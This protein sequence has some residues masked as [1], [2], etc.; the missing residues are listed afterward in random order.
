MAAKVFLTRTIPDGPLARLRDA[1]DL[2]LWPGD[3]PPPRADLL[4]R[5]ADCDGLL[6]LLTDKI[7]G[8]LLDAAPRLRVVSQMAVGYE[9][10][11]VAAA[12]ARNI[13]V[14]NTPGVLTETTADLAWMLMLAAARRALDGVRY[15]EAGQWRTWDPVALLGA[16]VYGATLGI[17]GLGGIG[18]AVARRARGFDMRVLYNA[19]REKPEQAAEVGAS[20]A[21]FAT[22][23]RESDFI[24]I[25]SPLTPQTR[26]LFNADVFAQM[27]PGAVL[28]NTARGGIVDRDALLEAVRSGRLGAPVWM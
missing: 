27:K 26:K 14:G 20:Y 2:D 15:I 13:P 4:R 1:V 7:D 28:V 19:P 22:L 16:D 21:D 25:H 8:E 17:Y 12:T 18:A 10:I 6:C 3:M 24:S 23:L 5:V 9:N 11:D